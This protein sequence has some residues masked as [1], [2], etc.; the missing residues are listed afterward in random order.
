[1]EKG[2]IAFDGALTQ[3][4]STLVISSRAFSRENPFETSVQSKF[5]GTVHTF[6]STFAPLRNKTNEIKEVAVFARDITKILNGN[7]APVKDHHRTLPQSVGE[8]M[9][10]SSYGISHG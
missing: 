7:E 2:V 5:D 6:L 9:N 4:D 10:N 8:T 3:N 1:L